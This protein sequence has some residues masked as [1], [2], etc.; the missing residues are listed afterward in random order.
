MVASVSAPRIGVV[1]AAGGTGSRFGRA[2]GKQLAPLRGRTV[3]AWSLEPLVSLPGV[4]EVVV[5]C[6]P[7]RRDEFAL[8][9]ADVV[10]GTMSLKVVGG[11]STRQRSVSQ[12]LEA[13]TSECDVVLVHDGARPLITSALAAQ[14]LEALLADPDLEGVV[15]GHPSVDTLKRVSC[16]GGVCRVLD[17]PDRSAYWAVQ[18]PQVFRAA[19]LRS[20]HAAATEAG[21]E[22][23]DDSSLVEWSGGS[24]LMVEGPRDNIKVTHEEDLAIA[25]S[26]LAART[27][28]TRP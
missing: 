17:T 7:D 26:I 13:L 19:R 27:G 11:G 16:V 1:I 20:A 18:T 6:D 15:V 25:E 10:P 21:F 8:Q 5:V 22:A 12:G 2:E 24:V 9:L 14:A 28:G 3:L 4:A 23:T